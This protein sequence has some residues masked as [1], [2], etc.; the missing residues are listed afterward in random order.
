MFHIAGNKYFK[1]GRQD[2]LDIHD[3]MQSLPKGSYVT[4]LPEENL[5]TGQI[6]INFAKKGR[7][8]TLGEMIKASKM[9]SEIVEPSTIRGF[10]GIHN[11]PLSSSSMQELLSRGLKPKRPWELEYANGYMPHFNTQSLHPQLYPENFLFFPLKQRLQ[12]TTDYISQFPGARKPFIGLDGKLK[13][14]IPINRKT[15]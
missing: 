3:A 5:I 14:S 6:G 10:P 8:P 1:L 9:K 12:L 2:K 11:T 13:I 15:K 7:T 4:D